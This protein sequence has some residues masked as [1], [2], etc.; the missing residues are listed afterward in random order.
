MAN[1]SL[2]FCDSLFWDNLILESKD[3]DF[4]NCFQKTFFVWIP[5][6]FLSLFS[7]LSLFNFYKE[8]KS[9]PKYSLLLILKMVFIFNKIKFQLSILILI[10]I[11]FSNIIIYSTISKNQNFYLV[12][13]MKPVILIL[14]YIF[15]IIK[16]NILNRYSV[17]FNIILTLFWI[18]S[19]LF[20]I[21]I[22]RSKILKLP[23]KVSDFTLFV[24]SFFLI[25]INIFLSLCS[26]NKEKIINQRIFPEKYAN[27]LSRLTFSWISGLIYKGY[28]QEIN[29]NDVW[30]MD[31]D[32]SCKKLGE[33]LEKEWNKMLSINKKESK[34]KFP[35]FK[36]SSIKPEGIDMEPITEFSQGKRKKTPSL[37]WCLIKIH[38]NY[39]FI[40]GLLLL[41]Q[42]LLE[43]TGPLLLDGLIRFVSNKK[44]SNMIGYF[45]ASLLFIKLIIQSFC[46]HHYFH[47]SFIAGARTRTSLMN[48]IYKKSL[49]LST[50]SRRTAT[51]G[52]IINLMQLNT[53]SFVELSFHGHILWAGPL[54][55]VLSI[56][57]LW[58]YLGPAVFAGVG[59]L[60]LLTPLNSLLMRKYDKIESKKLEIKDTRVKIINEILNGIKNK[61]KFYGWETS[62]EKII[63]KIRN[64]EL[65][66]LRKASFFY[67]I[68]Y[69]S[70][71]F[72][73][74]LATLVSLIAFIYSSNKNIL[75][76]STAYVTLSLFNLIRTPLFFIAPAVSYFIQARVSLDRI[77]K[78]LL[79]EEIDLNQ[80]THD[81]DINNSIVYENVDLSW[82][83]KNQN[84]LLKNINLKITRGKLVAIV[85]KVGCGKSSLLSSVLGEMYKIKGKI[86]I[87]GT[88]S[89]VPQQAWIQNETVRENILFGGSFDES[90]YNKVIKSCA[91]ITDLNILP[92][93]DKTEIGEKGINLSGGQKQR[94]S[95]ARASYH[96]ADIYLL[97]DPLSAVDAHVGKHIFDNV[98]GPNGILKDKTRIFVTNTISFLPEVDQIIL[99]ENGSII[100]SGSYHELI[101][102][103]NT[104][105]YQFIKNSFISHG[106]KEIGDGNSIK[107]DSN[108]NNLSLDFNN[109]INENIVGEK[110]IE[111]EKME[112]GNVKLDSI[113]EYFK[114]CSFQLVCL[115]VFA[116]ILMNVFQGLANFWLSD[117]SNQNIK[118]TGDKINKNIRILVYA[119]LGFGQ[120]LSCFSGEMVSVFMIVN[121]SKKLHDNMFKSILKS[122]MQ[123]FESTPIGRILNRFSKDL[124]SVDFILPVSFKDFTYCLFDSLTIIIMISITTPLFLTAM[125]PIAILYFFIQRYYV[126]SSSKLK[127]LD[128]VSK[129]PIFSHFGETLNGVATIKAYNSNK[130]FIELIEKKIDNNNMFMYP[131]SI[132]DRWLEISLENLGNLITLS[133]TIFAIIARN[134]ISPGLA[135]LS[136]S[137]SLNV[138]LMLRYMVRMTAMLESNLTSIERMKEYS[139]TPQEADW[140]NNNMRPSKDWPN[141]GTIKFVNYSIKYRDELDYA[142][143]SI[144][145]EIKSQEKIGIV[146]RTGAGKSSLSLGLFRIL[147]LKEGD[148][149]IDDISIKDI[150]LHDLRQKLTIIPQEPVLFSGTLRMNLDPFEQ[151]S[152]I[153]LWNVLEKAHLREFVENLENKL[154]FECSEGGENLSVGQRQLLC[155]ARALLRNSKVLVLDEATSAIDHNTDHLIQ[156]TIRE[157]FSNCTIL[158]IAHR[159]NT[160]LDSDRIM[161]LDKGRVI[162]FDSPSKLLDN[163]ESVFY[164]MAL[165][166]GITKS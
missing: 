100:E 71:G 102:D 164:S 122:T 163:K 128:S 33:D 68:F 1:F 14:T 87:D 24:I 159:L 120:H 34:N 76:P 74:F 28:K 57:L 157:A 44:Q 25:I 154:L 43:L 13:I 119:L 147:E 52:E 144:N 12:E 16:L 63:N 108:E 149:I 88:M 90:L 19:F 140:I 117:W 78:F 96:N 4:T 155:M 15:I 127:R 60:I 5:S 162:E 118:E 123:F 92:A 93:G 97:D 115:F 98:I 153:E 142:L 6:L 101:N 151:F 67:S 7:P 46:L 138:S 35:K 27:L 47:N 40:S 150:G 166:S 112:T 111:V 51:S 160:I 42:D 50:E 56:I 158:T 41:I 80:I 95:L 64:S 26:E 132:S 49:K 85:G 21:L 110:I 136:I 39:L 23:I 77:V 107:K 32:N 83:K 86:N 10:G 29:Q 131:S 148:I 72:T 109:K 135:G 30:D 156:A 106:S 91:L 18:I 8:K 104:S 31:K 129:S 53:Q 38:W 45:L 58:F 82:N 65:K 54:K 55:I 3:P 103:K 116:Y 137:F 113:L 125:V 73:T 20:S 37:G 146:G 141:K 11:E 105:F 79:L 84:A 145:C 9:N 69:F 94:V 70:F 126:S 66:F 89:Y 99:I 134:S 114:S 62:F 121:S 165:S 130:R 17:K 48:L 143:K 2:K 59:A 139:H 22:L 36:S 61:L 81:K 152:D 133:A 161:V 124:S 75:D